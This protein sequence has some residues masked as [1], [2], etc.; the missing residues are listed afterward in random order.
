MKRAG[1]FLTR[2]KLFE[3]LE[4]DYILQ[5]Q[6]FECYLALKSFTYFVFELRILEQQTLS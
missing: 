3:V 6:V 2:R 5:F 4:N 1:K